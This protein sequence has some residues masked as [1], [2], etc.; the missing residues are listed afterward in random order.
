[1]TNPIVSLIE[2][3]L[4][5]PVLSIF[6][7]SLFPITLKVINGNREINPWTTVFL[8]LIGLLLGLGFSL[9]TVRASTYAF[10]QTFI[11]DGYSAFATVTIILISIFSLFLSKESAAT[12]GRLFSEHVFLMMN[13]TIGALIMSWSNDLMMLFIGMEYMSLCLYILIAISNEQKL[14]KEAALKYF[15][16]GSFA[17]AIFLFGMSFIFGTTGT[18]ILSEILPQ[19][20]DLVTT[21]RLFVVGILLTIVGLGFKVALFPFHAWLPD[22]YQGSPTSIVAYMATMV[23]VAGFVAILRFLGL[24][25]LTAPNTETILSVLEWIAVL[26][27]LVGNL[28]ALL[29]TDLKRMLA[30]SGIAHS[31]YIMVGAIATGLTTTSDTDLGSF[32]YL[33]SSGVLFYL[34]GYSIMT[35]GTF[36]IVALF[37]KSED[38]LVRVDDLKGLAKK[39]PFVAAGFTL[40]L[41]SLAG[42]PP[43]IGFFG[44]LFIFTAAIKQGLFWLAIW[45]VINSVISVYYYLRP[46]V[47]MY[48]SEDQPTAYAREGLPLSKFT[49]FVMSILVVVLGLLSEPVYRYVTTTVLG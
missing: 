25:Y 46:V 40:L 38:H 28:L 2:I 24:E 9:A 27:M 21:Q 3:V 7:F 22:V 11:F 48:M 43:T 33:G 10:S 42:I 6:F 12:K 14:S 41:V 36:G 23:K 19:A 45:G 30:Y 1:M 49:I 26:T 31:G 20:A 16:L 13:A 4:S 29:Q 15:V 18:T 37:E 44:K 32:T 35:L 8:A 34:L 17:S 47:L 5:A 39:Q